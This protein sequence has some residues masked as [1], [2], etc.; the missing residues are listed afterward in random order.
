MAARIHGLKR[1][2]LGQER[3]ELK[4]KNLI[5]RHT[6]RRKPHCT[7]F[8]EQFYNTLL[9]LPV[10]I[11][12]MIMKMP[13][14]HIQKGEEHLPK[15]FQLLAQRVEVLAEEGDTMATVMFDGPSGLYGGLGWQF[16][17]YL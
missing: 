5:N 11:F 15:R 16:C 6:F 1:D 13:F 3:M 2:L 8:L 12:G 7:G 4:A 9:V 17:R 10:T 14:G